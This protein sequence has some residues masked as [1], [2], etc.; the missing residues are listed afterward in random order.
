M[1]SRMT[2]DDFNDRGIELGPVGLAVASLDRSVDFYQ[3]VI[4][5]EV[6]ERTAGHARLGAGSRLLLMLEE[7]AG[8]VRD[9]AAA[10]LFHFAL[11]LPS[12]AALGRQLNHLLEAGAPLT[13]A[14]DHNVSE[15][16]YLDDPDGHG[17]E[18][19]R[20]RPRDAWYKDGRFHL[21]TERLELS[22]LVAEGRASARG[23]S[24]LEPGTVMGHVHLQAWDLALAR[25][26]YEETLGLQ[27]M[28]AEPHAVFL[29]AQGYHHH[30]AVN[31]WQRKRRPAAPEAGGIGLL[32]YEI[33]LPAGPVLSALAARLPAAR[34]EDGALVARD[35]NGIPIRFVAA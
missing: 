5:L 32:G 8:A 27:V 1:Q 21:T 13:G 19:Y 14:S 23:W 18:L 33:R 24:G 10:D 2:G 16:L 9:P 25:R 30:I 3:R 22:D 35:P 34:L 28:A 15:A 7:R 31:D 29:S 20:D 26:F 11:L 12:R 6:L 4:G 17:I